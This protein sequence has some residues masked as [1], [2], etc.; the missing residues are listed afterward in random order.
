MSPRQAI[1][2]RRAAA[3]MNLGRLLT[4][5]SAPPG[6]VVAALAG[7]AVGVAQRA[8]PPE[9]AAAA[10][11]ADL[12]GVAVW[13]WPATTPP[14]DIGRDLAAARAALGQDARAV[15]VL[16]PKAR[17]LS[18]PFQGEVGAEVEGVDAVPLIRAVSGLD[19]GE[20]VR[21][22]DVPWSSEAEARVATAGFT[23]HAPGD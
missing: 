6:L 11:L 18:A 23:A 17:V 5:A 13:I 19:D 8:L 10:A 9:G 2:S 21:G 1:A 15:V 12:P 20:L 16:R 22:V 4:L 3:E 14:E 7:E